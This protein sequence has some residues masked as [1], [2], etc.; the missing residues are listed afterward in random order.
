MLLVAAGLIVRSL[1]RVQM[2]GPGFRTERTLTMSVDLGLQGY[3]EARGQEFYKEIVARAESLPGV[4]SA[5]L[6]NYLPLALNRNTT[7]IYID[8]QPIPRPADVPE[9]TSTTTR[10][11]TPSSAASSRSSSQ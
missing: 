2:I 9:I 11:W 8:G 3:T 1:Q 5:S 7:S 10:V 6:V 4:R